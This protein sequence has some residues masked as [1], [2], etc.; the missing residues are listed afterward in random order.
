MKLLPDS[1]E[2]D[3][4]RRLTGVGQVVGQLS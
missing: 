4:F 1:P 3:L 2:A